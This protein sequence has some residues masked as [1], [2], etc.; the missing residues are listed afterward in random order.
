MDKIKQQTASRNVLSLPE[1]LRP[2]LEQIYID[3]DTTVLENPRITPYD[4]FGQQFWDSDDYTEVYLDR[5]W[6]LR[7]CALVNKTWCA[8]ALPILW[9]HAEI[10]YENDHLWRLDA[11]RDPA[12]RE[13]YAHLVESTTV[14]TYRMGFSDRNVP[15]FNKDLVFPSLKTLTI[16]VDFLAPDIPRFAAEGLRELHVDPHRECYPDQWV[17]EGT[18]GRIFDE[19]RVSLSSTCIV[20][21]FLSADSAREWGLPT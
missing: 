19:I 2:I 13:F 3:D 16:L 4:A 11:I 1:L 8:L 17:D 7:S 18:M 10:A 9:R 12:R 21:D 14:S 6:T 15:L 5:S 20:F